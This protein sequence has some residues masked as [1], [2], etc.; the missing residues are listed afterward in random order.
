MDSLSGQQDSQ[1]RSYFTIFS[2]NFWS[3]NHRLLIM[4]ASLS[5]IRD[6]VFF[7]SI[8]P[9]RGLYHRGES[10]PSPLQEFCVFIKRTSSSLSLDRSEVSFDGDVSRFAWLESFSL[11]PCPRLKTILPSGPC[12]HWQN[13]E[14]WA[15]SH[16]PASLGSSVSLSYSKL[17]PSA[18]E[19]SWLS[20]DFLE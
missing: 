18:I 9:T 15:M 2:L 8:S 17:S 7:F 4:V 14:F 5:R 19:R 12:W 20:V 16:C 13:A 1:G 10:P 11:V 3:E 6:V